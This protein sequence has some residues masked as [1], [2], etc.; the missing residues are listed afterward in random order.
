MYSFRK[1]IALLLLM[2]FS[3][4]GSA[5]SET[6]K[7]SN[8]VSHYLEHR[9]ENATGFTDFLKMHYLN[10]DHTDNDDAE[11]NSLP[12]LA[13]SPQTSLAFTYTQALVFKF[14]PVKVSS[15]ERKIIFEES[16]LNDPFTSRIWQPPR[17]Y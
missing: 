2:I 6:L 17:F 12:F 13:A 14:Q 1:I 7:V 15:R 11:D 4:S 8:L 10:E 3:F 16:F 9:K 5:F